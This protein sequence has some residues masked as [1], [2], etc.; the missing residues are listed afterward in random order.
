MGSVD[1]RFDHGAGDRSLNVHTVKFVDGQ[2]KVLIMLAI[3]G[4]CSELELTEEDI[5]TSPL[6]HVL[7]TF[8]SIRC[9]FEFFENESHHFLHSLS[10]L[11][12]PVNL[13]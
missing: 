5:S 11:S 2:T 9:H 13:Q 12:Y 7:S 4:F 1:V 10:S 3:V 8:I 6:A